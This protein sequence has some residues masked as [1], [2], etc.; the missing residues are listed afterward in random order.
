MSKVE[1]IRHIVNK[2]VASH[3]AYT[4]LVDINIHFITG[5]A[6]V[7]SK[8]GLNWDPRLKREGPKLFLDL[9]VPYIY[10]ILLYRE[11]GQA[12]WSPLAKP[13]IIH[14]DGNVILSV[15]GNQFQQTCERTFFHC[16][17]P[18]EAENVCTHTMGGI[19]CQTIP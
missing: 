2:N 17:I 4:D 12:L 6:R 7:L 18:E 9:T 16:V 14:I 11:V 3:T 15:Q 8:W 13:L 5:V 1:N 10:H 19:I